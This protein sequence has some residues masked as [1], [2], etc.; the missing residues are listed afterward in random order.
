ML[1]SCF[2][3][4]F[5]RESYPDQNTSQSTGEEGESE[6]VAPELLSEDNFQLVLPSGEFTHINLIE[7]PVNG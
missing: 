3:C 2:L 6:E 5:Y 1:Y 7:W 4:I